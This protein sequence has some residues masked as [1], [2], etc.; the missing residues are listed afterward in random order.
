MN[1]EAALEAGLFWG[2]HGGQGWAGVSI[3]TVQPQHTSPSICAGLT[4][5]SITNMQKT[6]SQGPP[7]QSTPANTEEWF[8]NVTL[9]DLHVSRL[10]VWQSNFFFFAFSWVNCET[11]MKGKCSGWWPWGQRVKGSSW[12]PLPPQWPIRHPAHCTRRVP[13]VLP[14]H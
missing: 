14:Q 7:Q 12:S 1:N 3:Y 13:I 4:S 2:L 5:L 10:S 8:S 6:T 9:S 11:R